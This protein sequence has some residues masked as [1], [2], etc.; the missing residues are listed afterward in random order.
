MNQGV[1]GPGPESKDS[2]GLLI[3][4]FISVVSFLGR[5]EFLQRFAHPF[6][7]QLSQEENPQDAPGFGTISGN[8]QKIMVEQELANCRVLKIAKQ[9]S[10]AFSMMVTVGRAENNDIIIR[11]GK[12]SKFHAYFNETGSDWFITDGNSS[13]GT[14]VNGE[15]LKP[16]DRTPIGDNT[17]LS[18]SQFLR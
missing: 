16:G 11:N 10:N 2:E 7:I 4:D 1:G 8:I 3:K 15:R 12:V 18:F 13:N 6:L 14:F 9:A 5:D 17:D